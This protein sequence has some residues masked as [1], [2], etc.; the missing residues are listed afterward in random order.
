[1]HPN[2]AR[3]SR[4]CTEIG[5]QTYGR[6]PHEMVETTTAWKLQRAE[7]IA[8]EIRALIEAVPHE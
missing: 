4:L 1:M 6:L 5:L 2:L 7:R 8:R 3:A